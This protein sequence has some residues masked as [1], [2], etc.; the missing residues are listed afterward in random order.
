MTKKRIYLKTI[1]LAVILSMSF[2]LMPIAVGMITHSHNASANIFAATNST[3]VLDATSSVG[4]SNADFTSGS[5]STSSPQTPSNWTKANGS[6]VAP[7]YNGIINLSTAY[8]NNNRTSYGLSNYDITTNFF[9]SPDADDTKLLILNSPNSATN[10]G[11]ATSSDFTLNADCFYEIKLLV[12]TYGNA[13]ASIYLTGEGL[14]NTNITNITTLGQW[15]EV[16]MFVKTGMNKSIAAKL[17]LFLGGKNGNTCSGFVCFD[18]VKVMQ[19]SLEEYCTHLNTSSFTREFDLTTQN[20]FITNSDAYGFVKNGIFAS[21]LSFWSNS[22]ASFV[23]N[24]DEVISINGENTIIGSNQRGIK[25]GALLVANNTS[26][27]LKSSN[28]SIKRMSLYRIS[29]WAK[30]SITSGEGK[31]SIYGIPNSE[32]ALEPEEKSASISSM[33]TGSALNNYWTRYDFYVKGDS[34]FDTNCYLNFSL[35]TD[36][37]NATGYIAIAD[38]KSEIVTESIK[39]SSSSANSNNTT[40]SMQTTP[41]LNFANST[42]NNVVIEDANVFEPED[43]TAQN[44]NNT[45]SG[46]VNVLPENWSAI[47]ADIPCPA[48]ASGISDNVLMIRNNDAN[49]YQ[50]FSS[51]SASLSADGYAQI[52]FEAFTKVNS[53]NSFVTIASDNGNILYEFTLPNESGWKTYNLYIKNFSTDLTLTLTLSLGKDNSPAT[54]YAFFDNCVF[55]SN[56]TEDNFNAITESDTTIKV[57]LANDQIIANDNGTPR[58]MSVVSNSA[59]ADFGIVK[60]DEF[61]VGVS[62]NSI[63][64]HNDSNDEIFYIY[65]K[66]PTNTSIKTNFAYTFNANTYYKVSV[67]AKTILVTKSDE[68][69]YDDNG[70]IVKAGAMFKIDGV[71]K[72]F[73]NINTSKSDAS[74]TAAEA[75]ADSSNK[76]TEYTIY[77]NQENSV[78][79]AVVFGLGN[80][81]IPSSGYVFFS[82]LSIKS[83]SED[84]YKSQTATYENDVPFNVILATTPEEDTPEESSTGFDSS[85]W[86]AIPTTII[87]IAVLVAII[88]YFIRKAKANRPR[89]KEQ[90]S[91]ADYDRLNTLLKDVDKKE[92]KSEIK[93][94]INLLKEELKQSKNYLAEEQAE[95]GKPSDPEHPVDVKQIEKSIEM[96]KNKITEIELD[97]KVLEEE[98][99]K[100]VSKQKKEK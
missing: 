78:T 66:D 85:A 59:D 32:T 16:S 99:E 28:I 19:Y 97:L 98:Y 35:G 48:K 56:T 24:F 17:E 12:Y 90:I 22:N 34:R 55:D 47:G 92:R 65:S 80:E 27:N 57:N 11:Y 51:E 93:H 9:Y 4:L 74:Q 50:A 6:G 81:F 69:L 83:I 64:T 7:E 46:V 79:G 68:F 71:N 53:G 45:A 87:G 70:E 84:E 60:A 31:L 58:Y 10:Y 42:F 44:S 96:Q 77:L 25:S 14:E 37:N 29:V 72:Y 61:G 2:V 8:F 39:S 49:S 82:D 13:N 100:I 76:W 21:D 62:K 33:V 15:Q 5:G 54:G 95:L 1:L 63:T 91:E 36:T 67:W 30:H 20:S 75:F 40:L 38:I 41:E 94:K 88:G 89:Q 52:S 26:A 73:T 86:F 18:N 3:K 23:T 43:W